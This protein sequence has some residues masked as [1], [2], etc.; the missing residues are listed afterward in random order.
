[1]YNQRMVDE[2]LHEVGLQV[3][4]AAFGTDP[5][6]EADPGFND[7]HRDTERRHPEDQD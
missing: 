6:G 3:Q 5:I 2:G 4:A 7:G 1:M